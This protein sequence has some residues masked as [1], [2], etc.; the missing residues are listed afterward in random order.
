MFSY[1]GRRWGGGGG[2]GEDLSS[3][4]VACI[5]PTV[6]WFMDASSN[7]VN[8]ELISCSHVIIYS[9]QDIQSKSFF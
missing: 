4:E 6:C 9:V 8:Q 7:W 1:F 5:N 3:S 2:G